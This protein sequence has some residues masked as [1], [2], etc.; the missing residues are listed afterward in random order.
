V[1]PRTGWRHCST[2]LN[3]AQHCSK[4]L[5]TAQHCSKL[6]NIAQHSSTLLNTAQH[7]SSLFK[8]A[9]HC[10]TLLNTAQ[11]C[12]TLLKTAQNC[13]TLPSHS[14]GE[15][16]QGKYS[17]AD[18]VRTT[19]EPSQASTLAHAPLCSVSRKWHVYRFSVLRVQRIVNKTI[20]DASIAVSSHTTTEQFIKLSTISDSPA[21]PTKVKQMLRLPCT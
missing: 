10:S 8:T 14:S 1:V 17:Q 3:T 12:S 6:L 4:L 9:Q 19:R 7:C 15:F 11:N 18:T 16:A 21:S 5:N 20:C 2:L 13:S